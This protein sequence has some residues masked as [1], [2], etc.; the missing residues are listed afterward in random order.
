MAT[1]PSQSQPDS[2]DQ[3]EI[4]L[5]SELEKLSPLEQGRLAATYGY[6]SIEEMQA[7]LELETDQE[8]PE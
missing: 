4:D 2:T 7:A 8:K 5:K 3:N 6:D 1:Q